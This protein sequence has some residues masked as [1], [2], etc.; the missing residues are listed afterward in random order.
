[1]IDGQATDELDK[2]DLVLTA[3]RPTGYLL[4]EISITIQQDDIDRAAQRALLLAQATGRTVTPYVIGAWEKRLSAGLITNARLTLLHVICTNPRRGART[5]TPPQHPEGLCGLRQNPHDQNRIG[6]APLRRRLLRA[7]I[8]RRRC[9]L[10][11]PSLIPRPT[12]RSG[13]TDRSHARPV[14]GRR[15]HPR[16][17][18]RPQLPTKRT[19]VPTGT[20]ARRS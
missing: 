18:R 2:T 10:L 13:P 4:A 1:M 16:H 15:S 14:P 20:T 12:G 5:G 11:L 19:Y 17:Q 8:R 6:S 9:R 7:R 3:D